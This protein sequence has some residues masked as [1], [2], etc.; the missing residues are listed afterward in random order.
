MPDVLYSGSAAY[1]LRGLVPLTAK[2]GLQ[3]M[4]SYFVDDANA[5]SV[6]GYTTA[7][8][9]LGFE[10]PLPLGVGLGLRGFVAVENLFDRRYVASAFLN[11]DVVG[12][13]PVAFEP[14]LPRRLVV[15]LSLGVR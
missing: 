12:G 2:L 14:G 6:A 9:T 7:N 13:V 8:L 5:V 4:S 3:G 15:S 11:P 10:E 1:T